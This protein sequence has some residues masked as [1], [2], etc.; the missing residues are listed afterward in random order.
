MAY[1]MRVVNKTAAA[2]DFKDTFRHFRS[3]GRGIPKRERVVFVAS[4]LS[5]ELSE[6]H[7]KSSLGVPS[8]LLLQFHEKVLFLL[9]KVCSE[10]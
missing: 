3:S 8:L 7:I 10:P 1:L 9:S 4:M 6:G 2:T 5:K